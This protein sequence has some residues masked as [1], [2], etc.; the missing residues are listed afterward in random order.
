M[1]MRYTRLQTGE[2]SLTPLTR[3]KN[4]IKLWLIEQ[5][6]QDSLKTY[7][8]EL[9]KNMKIQINETLLK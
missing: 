1:A 8:D 9:K 5:K 3:L 4:T 7:I 2:R 6:I